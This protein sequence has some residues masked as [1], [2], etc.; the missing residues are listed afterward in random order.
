MTVLIIPLRPLLPRQTIHTSLDGKRYT[1]ELDWN[2]RLGLWSLGLFSEN[3]DALF[4]GEGLAVE[5]DVL[6]GKRHDPRI[7]QGF[8]ALHD[9][10]GAYTEA[11][12][13][14]LG[15]RHKLYFW[16]TSEQP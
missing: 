16:P 8:F 9:V 3:G 10:T 12:L 15:V 11:T 2:A 6:R 14:S 1:L 5:Y 13:D 4:T 7:P